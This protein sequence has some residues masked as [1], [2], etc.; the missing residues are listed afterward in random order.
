MPD[1]RPP[2]DI[3]VF[4]VPAGP[5]RTC[6]GCRERGSRSSLLRVVLV[7]DGTGSPG[8][9]LD[10]A[11][12]LPG[13]GAWLHPDLDCLALAVR[14]KAFGRALRHAGP[15]DTGALEQAVAQ[16]VAARESGAGP[17]TTRKRVDE[18]DGC[19]MSTHR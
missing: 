5:V 16:V 4:Q 18:A 11:A 9:V 8:L 10:E 13:R 1:R 12:R 19:P 2:Y 3:V 14:R 17:N 7:D 15:L 6:V